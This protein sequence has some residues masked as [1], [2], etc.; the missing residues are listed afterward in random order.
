M[1]AFVTVYRTADPVRA[2]ML[3]DVLRQEGLVARV[4][5]TRNGALIGVAQGVL[6]LRIEVPAQQASEAAAALEA[7]DQAAEAAVEGE[8]GAPEDDEPSVATGSRDGRRSAILAAGAAFVCPGG[9][10]VY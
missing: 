4:I 1:E 8:A 7:Y 3:A 2:E 10:H 9:A 5:G 6:A